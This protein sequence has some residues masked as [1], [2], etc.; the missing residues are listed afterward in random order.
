MERSTAHLENRRKR[1][2]A[3]FR[4]QIFVADI[5]LDTVNRSVSISENGDHLIV[6]VPLALHLSVRFV[7]CLLHFALVVPL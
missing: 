3:T 4:A 1:D 7:S 6:S 5:E 2:A